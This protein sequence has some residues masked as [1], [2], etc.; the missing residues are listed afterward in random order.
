MKL[1]KRSAVVG[2]NI[3]RVQAPLWRHLASMN[4]LQLATDAFTAVMSPPLP[5]RWVIKR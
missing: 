2:G 1:N 5:M 4:D 3:Q